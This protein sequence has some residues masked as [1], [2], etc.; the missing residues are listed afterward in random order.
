MDKAQTSWSNYQQQN[1]DFLLVIPG[2]F[3][4]A[5]LTSHKLLNNQHITRHTRDS[6]ILN[7]CY[8]ILRSAYLSV[9]KAAAG[10]CVQCLVHLLPTNNKN[11]K[12]LQVWEKLNVIVSLY[13]SVNIL[14]WGKPHIHRWLENVWGTPE[15]VQR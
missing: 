14:T 1:P 2:Y 8:N 7:H 6:S 10:Q 12:H 15:N 3:N 11:Q 9:P 13:Y 4:R 5:D